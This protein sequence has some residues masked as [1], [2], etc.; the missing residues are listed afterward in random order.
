MDINEFSNELNKTFAGIKSSE[1]VLH[2]DM[3][4]LK[5]VQP[6]ILISQQ[7]DN[8]LQ[9][10]KTASDERTLL[11]PTFNYDF[12]KTGLYD[13]END[14]CQVGAFNEHIRK[15]FPKQRT[16]TPVFNYCIINNKNFDFEIKDNPFD[17]NSIFADMVKNKT[18]V[19]FLGAN[20]SSNTFVHYSEEIAGIGYRYHKLFSGSVQT[21]EQK[22]ELIFKYRVRPKQEKSVDYDW[23][24]IELDLTKNGLLHKSESNSCKMC[25]FYADKAHDFILSKMKKDEFYLLTPDSKDKILSLYAQYGKPLLFEKIEKK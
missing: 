22:S 9:H 21:S 3:F 12:L 24:K 11:F 20:F 19:A 7:F 25:Y 2:T 23:Q 1:I 10:L 13:V 16:K 5:F 14:I 4:G 6:R 15:L 17:Q 18:A 8:L